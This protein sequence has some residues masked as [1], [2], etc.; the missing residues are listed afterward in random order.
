[1]SGPGLVMLKLVSVPPTLSLNLIGLG[2]VF[3]IIVCLV[4]TA[5]LDDLDRWM[6][7]VTENENL[8]FKLGEK[9]YDTT[10]LCRYCV[11]LGNEGGGPDGLSF[12]LDANALSGRKDAELQCFQ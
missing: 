3:C 4:M 6:N 9:G 11:A 8:E 5:T 10:K 7:S 12:Y 1:M 2:K